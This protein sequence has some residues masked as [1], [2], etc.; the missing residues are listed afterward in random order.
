MF[1]ESTLF[2]LL[3]HS[4]NFGIVVAEALASFIPVITTTGAPWEELNTHKCGWWID[5]SVEN[6]KV[7]LQ[8]AMQKSSQEIQ[9]M[10]LNGR[11]L[12]TENYDVKVV[13]QNIIKLYQKVLD[14]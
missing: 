11:K 6:L 13:A 7:T 9:L 10:G 2:V 8:E 12:V 3:T 14:K 4:E 5:L 1:R